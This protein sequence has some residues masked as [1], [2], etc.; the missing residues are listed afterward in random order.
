MSKKPLFIP[1]NTEYFNQFLI[2]EKTSELRLYGPRW[3]EHTCFIGRDVTLSKGY[4]KYHRLHGVI[5]EFH[6]RD[7][8]T[9]GSTYR[10]SIQ[11]LYGTLEKPI[12]E[13][14]IRIW[15]ETIY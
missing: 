15:A 11:K 7:A 9:F 13:I 10:N 12:A 6:K 5:S 4:G 1:L 8:K 14:R 3:N 2:G